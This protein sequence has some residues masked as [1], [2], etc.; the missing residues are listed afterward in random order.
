M[1]D[2]LTPAEV[3]ALAYSAGITNTN[4]LITATAIPARES[5]YD[6]TKHNPNTATQ[7]DS[8]G[9]WQIDVLTNPT[10][11]TQLGLSDKT[12]LTDPWNNARAMALLYKS[13]NNSFNAWGPYKGLSPTYNVTSDQMAAAAQGVAQA[14][15]N[16]WL[17]QSFADNLNK[18]GG[19]WNALASGDSISH[20]TN[21]VGSVAD[22]ATAIPD[23]LSWVKNA[24][25]NKDN[26]VRIGLIVGALGLAIFGMMTVS[27][28]FGGPGASDVVGA[29]VKGAALAA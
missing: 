1:T 16:G 4:D 20:G 12:Q 10:I 25:L 19:Q 11:L 22:A 5:G 17:T 24:V 28:S 7:D 6:P 26:W 9:L 21:A 2:T 14:Q 23:F 15:A 18:A 29:G 27:K 8:W 3:A 13:G